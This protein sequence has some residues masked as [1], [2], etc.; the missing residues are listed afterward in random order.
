M[1]SL[2]A[3]AVQAP[4][5]PDRKRRVHF[6]AFMLDIHKRLQVENQKVLATINEGGGWGKRV[7]PKLHDLAGAG[8]SAGGVDKSIQVPI[9]G[10]V[11]EV[12]D[13]CI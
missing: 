10:K 3:T 9:F 5:P 7:L 2:S 12:G 11:M 13:E 1:L 6:H 4:L 8:G